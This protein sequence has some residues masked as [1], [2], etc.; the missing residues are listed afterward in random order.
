MLNITKSEREI[1][2]TQLTVPS[3]WNGGCCVNICITATQKITL[4]TKHINPK[5]NTLNPYPKPPKP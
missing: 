2:Q 4:T 5:P 3:P 1:S